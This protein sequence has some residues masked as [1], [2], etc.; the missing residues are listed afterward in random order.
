MDVTN[1]RYSTWKQRWL[2]D[3]SNVYKTTFV[4]RSHLIVDVATSLRPNYIKTT[5]CVRLRVLTANPHSKI[6]NRIFI[7]TQ[8]PSFGQ[9]GSELVYSKGC[10]CIGAPSETYT[11]TIR[12]LR[13][14]F[15]IIFI[16][17]TLT[18]AFSVLY[19]SI[20]LAVGEISRYKN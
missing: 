7:L 15:L 17:L 11:E 13:V 20:S 5:S 12:I 2:I 19:I 1:G 9:S 6:W 8:N 3:V 10:A 4:I 16:W 14:F 18:K